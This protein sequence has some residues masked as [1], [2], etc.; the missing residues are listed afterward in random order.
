MSN[1]KF[2]LLQLL[3]LINLLTLYSLSLYSNSP[4]TLYQSHRS[5]SFKLQY[6]KHRQI[7]V[8]SYVSNYN[9]KLYN[10]Q[11]TNKSSTPSYLSALFILNGVAILWGTQ[12]VVI[13]SAL[14]IYPSSSLINFWRFILSTLLFSPSLIKTLVDN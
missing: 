14:D 12:H 2:S 6:R 5:Y 3:L 10:N 13:K 9:S 1:V 8:E 4:S 7:D 11:N